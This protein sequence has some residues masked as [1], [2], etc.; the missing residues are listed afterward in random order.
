VI[1]R[2]L[3]VDDSRSIR[4]IIGRFLRE[5]GF[6]TLEAANGREAL[7]VLSAAEKVDLALVDWNMPVMDGYQLV[8]ELRRNP[9]RD[10]MRILMVTTE[11]EI[12]RVSTALEAGASEYLMKPF[13]K[14]AIAGKLA[15][16]GLVE[17]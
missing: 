17:A 16:L 8:C 14:D 10:D 1:V 9:S 2:A 4:V 6:E 11:T 12:D 3:I 7:D 15:I 5:L 13:T